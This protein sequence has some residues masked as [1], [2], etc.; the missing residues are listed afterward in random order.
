MAKSVTPRNQTQGTKASQKNSSQ[1]Q[2]EKDTDGSI[3]QR[4]HPLT[5]QNI[6][7]TGNMTSR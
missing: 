3:T 4:H 1:A 2:K 5:N 6:L 7:N